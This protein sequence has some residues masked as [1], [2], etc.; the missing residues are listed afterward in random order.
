MCRC[1]RR[2]AAAVGYDFRFHTVHSRASVASD[3][4]SQPPQFIRAQCADIPLALAA[5]PSRCPRSG[6]TLLFSVVNANGFKSQAKG[7]SQKQQSFGD[8]S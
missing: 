4:F 1:F 5:L 2:F 8:L 3:A 7:S 6:A